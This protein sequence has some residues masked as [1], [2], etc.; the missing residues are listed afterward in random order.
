MIGYGGVHALVIGCGGVHACHPELGVR[1]RAALP[2]RM[3]LGSLGLVPGHHDSHLVIPPTLQRLW[4]VRARDGIQGR[5]RADGR[6]VRRLVRLRAAKQLA[7]VHTMRGLEDIGRTFA[8][9][10]LPQKAPDPRDGNA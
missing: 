9:F 2:L 3:F 8:E 10:Y 7:K 4:P 1:V 5:C 6:R